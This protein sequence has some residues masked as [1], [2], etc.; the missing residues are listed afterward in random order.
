VPPSR[1]FSDAVSDRHLGPAVD[2]PERLTG[3]DGAQPGYSPR[4]PPP[5]PPP[6]HGV[7]GRPRGF[8]SYPLI[9]AAASAICQPHAS[10]HGRPHRPCD[11]ATGAT[12]WS[13]DPA[14]PAPS[15][16]STAAAEAIRN[17]G[18]VFAV[19]ATDHACGASTPAPGEPALD[20]RRL[21]PYAF[22]HRVAADGRWAGAVYLT[23]SAA[24]VHR[25][26]FRESDGK[27][28][29]WSAR[30]TP[31]GRSSGRGRQRRSYR[32][33]L[34]GAYTRRPPTG[35]LQWKNEPLLRRRRPGSTPA[36]HRPGAL[37][38]GRAPVP[39]HAKPPLHR[40]RPAAPDGPVSPP[41]LRW[42][43]DGNTGFPCQTG[44]ALDPQPIVAT[45]LSAVEARHR[46]ATKWTFRRRRR[47]APRNVCSS[48]NGFVYV[49]SASGRRLR[50][51]EANRQQA[52][53]GQRRAGR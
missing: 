23:S 18:L 48:P 40:M 47:A 52:W 8:V 21:P 26:L 3:Y 12:D 49:A 17:A 46:P 29:V 50:G 28:G 19:N 6:L 5:P 10:H 1:P 9:S 7:D 38:A 32:P 37:Y 51:G 33:T 39:G 44:P 20:R 36:L 25:A 24:P 27:P 41:I 35:T 30:P 43:F 4:R 42:Q 34:R 45:T 31:R 16:S 11:A 15:G 14:S 53:F 2:V 13:A 22:H